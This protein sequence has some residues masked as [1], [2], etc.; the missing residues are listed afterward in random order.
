MILEVI[1]PWTEY[2]RM[3]MINRA[4]DAG[5][6]PLCSPILRESPYKNHILLYLQFILALEVVQ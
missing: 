1:G 6:I 5:G 2:Q 4:S 3:G